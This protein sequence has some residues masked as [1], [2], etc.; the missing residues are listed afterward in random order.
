MPN[1]EDHL[2]RV[3]FSDEV[4]ATF[5]WDLDQETGEYY[6]GSEEVVEWIWFRKCERPGIFGSEI[7]K[8]KI[9]ALRVLAPN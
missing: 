1:F 7:W 2:T 8:T 6:T 4:V 5:Q 3:H 9:T